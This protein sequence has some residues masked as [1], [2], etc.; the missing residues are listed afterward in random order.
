MN[1]ATVSL[2]V[3][4]LGRDD[5]VEQRGSIIVARPRGDRD[6]CAAEHERRVVLDVEESVV[7][8]A[9]GRPGGH[10]HHS[11]GGLAT[12]RSAGERVPA[13]RGD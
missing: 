4:D 10:L 11:A 1:E 3:L 13:Q 5:Y 12:W 6:F 7:E 9:I 8:P 2:S